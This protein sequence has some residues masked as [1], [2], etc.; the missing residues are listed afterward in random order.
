MLA[1]TAS[2][3]L[4]AQDGNRWLR[5]IYVG[6]SPRPVAA[7]LTESWQRA[8]RLSEQTD[9]S[10]VLVGTGSSMQPLYDPGTIMV[11]RQVPFA[12]LK[13]GQTVLYRNRQNKIVAHVLIARTRDGWRVQG[14][15]NPVHDMEP[16]RQENF[17]GVVIAAY[18]P[19]DRPRI[20]PLA[21]R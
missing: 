10:F 7:K 8:S 12:Q 15:N 20:V 1:C 18:S 2:A 19:T 14:L 21:A 16:I 5:G 6:E 13:R 9:Q 17:V 11:L 3:A 4:A